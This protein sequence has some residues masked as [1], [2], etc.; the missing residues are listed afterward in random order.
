MCTAFELQGQP[1]P[2]ATEIP[3][4]RVC[5]GLTAALLREDGGVAQGDGAEG[6]LL[7]QGECVMQGYWGMQA[8][9]EA[10]MLEVPGRGAFY[11]TGDLVRQE[12]GLLWYT[13]RKDAMVKVRG[14]RVE[15]G[16]VEAALAALPGVAEGAAVAVPDEQ[17]KKRLVAFMST[18]ADSDLDPEGALKALQERLPHYMIPSEVRAVERLPRTPNGKVDRVGLAR[19]MD[20]APGS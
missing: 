5:E 3:I 7:I 20:D 14:Y 6:E 16:E 2:E 13:G 19:S 9:S 11:R 17:G 8:E 1:E 10:V 18:A 15:L 4:G 12:A